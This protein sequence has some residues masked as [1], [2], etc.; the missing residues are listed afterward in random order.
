MTSRTFPPYASECRA[1]GHLF[2]DHRLRTDAASVMGPYRC[3][4]C[5]C[6][7]ERDAPSFGLTRT[8]FAARYPD[9]YR[10]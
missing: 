8:E 5:H 6:E 7:I 2:T 3:L 4:H 1:C 9:R 10:P